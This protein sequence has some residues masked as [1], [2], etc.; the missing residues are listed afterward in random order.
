LL[1]WQLRWIET[2]SPFGFAE[3][4]GADEELHDCLAN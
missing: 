1:L 2:A 3:G 4:T